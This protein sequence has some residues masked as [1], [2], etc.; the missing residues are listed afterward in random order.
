MSDSIGEWTS[1]H[2]QLLEHLEADP[3]W[4]IFHDTLLEKLHETHQKTT[5]IHE[6][7]KNQSKEVFFSQ[8]QW[9]IR[10]IKA[11]EPWLTPALRKSF[12][13]PIHEILASSKKE[14]SHLFW[15]ASRIEK[16]PAQTGCVI[17]CSDLL[18]VCYSAHFEKEENAFFFPINL[19]SNLQTKGFELLESFF[20]KKQDHPLF[21]LWK[22]AKENLDSNNSLSLLRFSKEI[23]NRARALRFEHYGP[24]ARTALLYRY[25]FF[26]WYEGLLWRDVSSENDTLAT[27][28]TK[29]HE[30]GL[31]QSLE[32]EPSEKKLPRVVH[33]TS[34]LVD[35]GHAPTNILYRLLAMSDRTRL[36][37]AVIITES[38]I[39]RTGDYPY[40]LRHNS[41]SEVRAPNFLKFL[42]K[43]KF[44]YLLERPGSDENRFESVNDLANRLAKRIN[45][46][47]ADVI[48]FHGTEPLHHALAS[49]LKSPLKILFEHGTLP[50]SPGFDIA[51][52][53]LEDTPSLCGKSLEALGTKIEVLPF[54]ADSRWG[55]K[56]EIPTKEQLGINEDYRIATTISN[57]LSS[58]MSPAFCEAINQ[59][60]KRVPDLVYAPI[61]KIEN[62]SEMFDRFDPSVRD[63]IKWLGDQQNPSQLTR[64]MDL[65]FNEFPFGSCYGILDA[66]ASGCPVISMY[67]LNGPPQ[68]RY[69]GLFMGLEQSIE[70]GQI[71][72]YVEKACSLL[73]NPLAYFKA[74]QISFQQYEWRS[75]YWAYIEQFESF[76]LKKIANRC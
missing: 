44:A 2:K 16:R 48:V 24:V 52:C 4:L 36:D 55:W 73:E 31:N 61:G 34:Q 17:L 62:P 76:I 40:H 37:Q 20:S 28:T 59:I 58:R 1:V 27:Q 70:T 67:D 60:L 3:S 46:I 7:I 13:L 32:R 25:Q 43:E 75:N 64:C 38:F 15:E 47:D 71:G 12:R 22:K 49:K 21:N 57:H 45:P 30:E 53:C 29:L 8:P 54:A 42:D 14:P 56:A 19:N 69:G 41:S 68:A 11:I 50:K 72:D 74:S 66:M 9:L 39:Q 33:V 26:D 18:S 10:R 6:A 23:Q 51:L 35:Q 63:R 65:Y 5:Q